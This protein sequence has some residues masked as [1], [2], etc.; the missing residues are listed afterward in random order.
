VAD[1]LGRPAVS[2]LEQ[3]EVTADLAMT[4]GDPVRAEGLGQLPAGPGPVLAS[5][6]VTVARRAWSG[7]GP[8]VSGEKA[9]TPPAANP[10]RAARLV[11]GWQPR[12]RAM[13]GADQPA[14]DS[15]TISSRLRATGG[16]SV[17][18]RA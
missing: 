2:R 18:R 8:G 6:P 4:K 3:P 13:R 16:R 10:R 14:S 11:C 7:S 17:R 5:R 12:C 15:K 1:G 9:A